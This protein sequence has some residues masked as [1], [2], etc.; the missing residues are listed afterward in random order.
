MRI[1][2]AELHEIAV[3]ND[4]DDD[5]SELFGIVPEVAF[6]MNYAG[7]S[8]QEL[9][10]FVEARAAYVAEEAGLVIGYALFGTVDD[11]A[12]L[13]QVSVRMRHQRRGVA[14]RLIEAGCDWARMRG[15]LGMTLTTFRDI[16]WNGPAYARL[17]FEPLE[18]ALASAE[19][20]AILAHEREIGLFRAPRIAMLRRLAP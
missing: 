9:Q 16:A 17:G 18:E 20:G 19:L 4:V 8:E 6:V 10:A 1:R 11:A 13:F 2:L 14:R 3:L 12:H 7:R 15:L 5:A